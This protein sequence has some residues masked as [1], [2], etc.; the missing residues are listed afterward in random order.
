[1]LGNPAF[2]SDFFER[3]SADSRMD[4]WN[5]ITFMYSHGYVPHKVYFDCVLACEWSDY[6]VQCN[7]DYTHPSDAC[8]K[9]TT[10]ALSYIPDNLDVYNIDAYS[11]LSN[12]YLN[13]T[14][15]F[16]LGAKVISEK[17][18]Q[19]KSVGGHENYDPCIKNYMTDYLNIKDVQFYIHAEYCKWAYMG[20]ILYSRE[21]FHSN[22]VPVLRELV[23]NK[24]SKAWRKVV[25]SG[26]F[27]AACPFPGTQKI[28]Y[29]L[30]LP[31]KKDYHQW[32]VEG[33]FAG[34]VT[35]YDGIDYVTIHGTGH[36]V[37]W[38]TPKL[39]FEFYSRWLS[40]KDL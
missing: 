9:A 28:M 37:P 4:A 17:R 6:M 40:G 16:S 8:Q 35:N 23:T 21:D 10:T 2:N 34:T 31:V 30:N 5:F 1:L 27:D 18:A 25:F 29:C 33:Q 13:Y 32:D 19:K 20:N 36:M 22:V 12:D 11:C 26:D 7:K 15:Q 38:Y 14:S 24:T 3:G 39:A